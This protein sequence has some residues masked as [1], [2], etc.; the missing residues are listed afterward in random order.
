MR[1]V[2]FDLGN[3][4]LDEQDRRIDGAIDTLEAIQRMCDPDGQ[5]LVL[6]LIS[7]YMPA[8]D[9]QH[10]VELQDEYYSILEQADLAP[11]FS[12]LPERVTLSTEVGV[13]KPDHRIFRA[14]LDKLDPAAHFHQAI[15]ITE[16]EAHVA[17]ARR[18]G[19]MA[20]HFKGPGQTTGE[21]EH[22]LE[23][24][25]LIERLI[26]F[27][28]CCKKPAEAIG[29]F[30]SQSNRSKRADAFIAALTSQISEAR[31]L[32]TMTSLTQ[33]G[34]RWAYS[35]GIARVPEWVH[36]QFSDM[37]YAGKQGPRYQEF[38]LPGGGPQ[39]NVL[40]GPLKDNIGFVLLCAHYDSLSET[41]E[42]LAPG[43][44]D[45][46]SGIAVLLEVAQLLKEV[47][48]KRGVL[49]AAFGGE[50]QG[51]FG[52]TACAEIAAQD[53]WPID[54]VINLDMIAFEDPARRGHIVVEYDQGHRHPGNDAA[55]KAYGLLMAQVAADYTSLQVEHTDIWNSDYMPFEAKGY[56]CIGVYEAAENPSYHQST[57]T[58]E[59]LDMAHLVEVTKMVLATILQ[60]TS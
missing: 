17:G 18:L 58:I 7:D 23:L 26:A 55:A 45:N 44:D 38:A 60:I 19:M 11:F 5:S 20:I 52:S 28:P 33:F 48:L 56:A 29:R 21:V 32:S 3:T 9:E 2:F 36:R 12:P 51:L 34:T 4:L 6:G 49:F 31:L 47:E 30:T 25:P 39:R 57:D 1:A 15:F 54:A 37:G 8:R 41:P 14:A 43:A 59:Q 24:V 16:K 53:S 42:T 13:Y 40:C 22:L 27:S 10:R 35:D 46:A 50:E